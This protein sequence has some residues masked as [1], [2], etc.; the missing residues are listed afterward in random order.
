MKSD[1]QHRDEEALLHRL[2]EHTARRSDAGTPSDEELLAYIAGTFDVQTT[3]RLDQRL[4]ESP[5]G[6]R[7]LLALQGVDGAGPPPHV[8]RRFLRSA[9]RLRSAR[10]RWRGPAAALAAVLLLAVGWSLLQK[11][12]LPSSLDYRVNVRGL[13]EVRDAEGAAALK[14]TPSTRLR[15]EVEPRDLAEREVEFGLYRRSDGGLLQ[16]VTDSVTVRVVRGA[17]T[18]EVDAGAALGES[19]GRYPL[20]LAVARPGDLPASIKLTPGE[21]PIDVIASQGRRRA[22]V[23][24]IELISDPFVR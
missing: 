9:E 17:A 24:S 10:S 20:W 6:R 2:A 15:F 7:R 23:T 22:Y 8:R 3:R 4:A 1:S 13:S 16:R 11:P 18:V 21:D 14:A 19:P 5:T 12:T